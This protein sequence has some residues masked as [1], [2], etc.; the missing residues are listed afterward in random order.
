MAVEFEI[1]N[2]NLGYIALSSFD[3]TVKDYNLLI[4]S[5]YHHDYGEKELYVKLSVLYHTLFSPPTIPKA[6]K[7]LLYFLCIE[8]L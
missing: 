1:L 6:S 8:S 4:L 3:V 7:E 2:N 5:S